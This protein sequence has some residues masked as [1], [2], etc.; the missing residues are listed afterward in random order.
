MKN[1]Q[2]SRDKKMEAQFPPDLTYFLN[3]I[4]ES[5]RGSDK[6]EYGAIH[7]SMIREIVEKFKSALEKSEIA[8]V[9]S[10][11]EN[12]IERLEFPLA[13]LSKYFTEKGQ[14]RLG[15]EDAQIFATFVSCEIDEGSVVGS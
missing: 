6:W 5:V 10:T 8:E 12:Q 7:V 15:K 4:H 3:K 9:G 2:Q 11:V 13:E 14:G 1:Q